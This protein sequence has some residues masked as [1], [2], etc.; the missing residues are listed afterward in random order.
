MRFRIKIN[1]MIMP[2]LGTYRKT[3]IFVSVYFIILAI[4]NLVGPITNIRRFLLDLVVFLL[5]C[6][7]II[8]NK[9]I[10]YLIFGILSFVLFGY[11]ILAVVS[12]HLKHVYGERRVS[13]P[14]EYFIFGYLLT[15]SSTVFAYLFIYIG[16][17]VKNI[18]TLPKFD[19]R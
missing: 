18:E 6:I 19:R 11:L 5:C 10:V 14:Y 3:K 9:R 13:N 2:H 8:L 1:H 16:V 4:M 7:P 17:N 15:V 12:D